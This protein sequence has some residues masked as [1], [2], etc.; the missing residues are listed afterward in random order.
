MKKLLHFKKKF[1]KEYGTTLYGLMKHYNFQP[2]EFLNFVHDV[3]LDK[4]TKNKN[5]FKNIEN[6]PGEKLFTQME[7]KIM[8]AE[9]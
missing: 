9:Y 4:I 3:N 2:K 5:L 1:Y 8:P 6:L 7:M